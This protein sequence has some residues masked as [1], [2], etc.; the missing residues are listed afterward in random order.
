MKK[1]TT[2]ALAIASITTFAL[3][4]C[5]C[6][7]TTAVKQ[8]L[9]N[10]YSASLPAVANLFF[11]GFQGNYSASELYKLAEIVEDGRITKG[12]VPSSILNKWKKCSDCIALR[13][14]GITIEFPMVGSA[15]AESTP[16]PQQTPQKKAKSQQKPEVYLASEIVPVE[17]VGAGFKSALLCVRLKSPHSK[18]VSVHVK[19]YDKDKK[20]GDDI[21][22]IPAGQTEAL[23]S[24]R[25][26]GFYGVPEEDI[27]FVVTLKIASIR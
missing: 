2:L 5:S 22:T 1:V 8:E 7:D 3:T 13:N 6:G 10:K 20:V 4:I 19:V 25:L 23:S 11:S 24:P 26:D 14:A 17:T 21:I 15:P 12:E 27:P 9:G 18:N 16:V